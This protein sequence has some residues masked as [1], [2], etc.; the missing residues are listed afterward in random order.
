MKA[1]EDAAEAASTA[2]Q[3][4]ESSGSGN[5]ADATAKAALAARL[6]SQVRPPPPQL[7]LSSQMT[8]SVARPLVRSPR[9][10]APTRGPRPLP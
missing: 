7:G 10:S 2:A 6:S 3:E 9:V 1:A 8:L 4:A 5:A